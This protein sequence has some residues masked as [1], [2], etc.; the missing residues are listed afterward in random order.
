M[1]ASS[2]KMEFEIL[3]KTTN[4]CSWFTIKMCQF[5]LTAISL[6]ACSFLR[7]AGP[8]RIIVGWNLFSVQSFGLVNFL[9]QESSNEKGL[10]MAWRNS[11]MLFF[12]S[13]AAS[14]KDFNIFSMLTTSQLSAS[15]GVP[16]SYLRSMSSMAA[17]SLR[18]NINRFKAV[19][20]FSFDK[21]TSVVNSP[22]IDR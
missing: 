1:D 12:F 9:P 19:W 15:S 13:L 11:L 5:N 14:L 2:Q 16:S 21:F 22:C 3:V 20:P 8:T 17:P 10:S 4:P 6:T 7:S 18:G